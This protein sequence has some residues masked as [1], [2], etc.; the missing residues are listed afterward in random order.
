MQPTAKYY[1]ENFGLVFADFPD[2]P[3]DEPLPVD[4]GEWPWEEGVGETTAPAVTET[5]AKTVTTVTAAA[6]TDG[7]QAVFGDVD[8]DGEVTAYDASLALM[9]FNEIMLDYAPEERT[10]TPAQEKTADV[11]GDSVLT[12]FD[13]SMILTYF[14]MANAGFDD[15]TWEEILPA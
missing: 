8:A 9:G 4:G 3:P 11:D 2:A 12:A 15:V 5:V 10:L 1:K 14:S 6:G 13:A 7:A